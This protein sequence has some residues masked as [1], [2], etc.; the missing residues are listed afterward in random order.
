MSSQLLCL[1]SAW[2]ANALLGF[3]C[4][5]DDVDAKYLL[6]TPAIAGLAV[7]HD[8]TEI[9][10]AAQRAEAWI[11]HIESSSSISTSFIVG[12]IKRTR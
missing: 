11:R 12:F 8:S 6:F 1:F 7:S 3:L 2:L 9:I 5:F 4:P 10:F